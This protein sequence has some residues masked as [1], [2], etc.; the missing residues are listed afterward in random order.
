MAMRL[1]AGIVFVL[2]AAWCL[3]IPRG[4]AFAAQGPVAEAPD[5]PAAKEKAEQGHP[6][7]ESGPG[8]NPITWHGINFP[9]DLALWT[10]VVFL[11]VLA[12]L[13]KYA[14]RPIADGL[15]KRERQVAEEIAQAHRSNE[16]ARQLLAQH[17][18]KLAAAADEVRGIV[19]E[20]RRSA[21]QIGRQMLDKARQEAQAERQ[22][23]L[24]EIDSAT[25][26]ALKELADRSATL[27][28]ELAGK[29]VGQRLDPKDHAK[30]IQE[31]VADFAGNGTKKGHG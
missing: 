22:R 24:Q 6:P 27:A 17:Q 13:W 15:E 31:A 10:G 23:A 25:S 16:E 8:L 18:Q 7:G 11:V 9:G 12:I 30:L 2:A 29:I 19:D 14:W 3:G 26:S 21:E 1:V 28:V 4:D 20:G 5:G